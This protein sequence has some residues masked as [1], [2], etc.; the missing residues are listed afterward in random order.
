MTRIACIIPARLASTRFPRKMLSE[1]WGKP[2][3]L[4]VWEAAKAVPDF[5]TVAVATDSEEIARCI[6][7]EGG[8]ALL[9]DPSCSSGTARLVE[10]MRKGTIHAD[11]WVNWQGDE[12]LIHAGMIKELLQSAN[13]LKSDIWTLRREIVNPL[14]LTNPHIT[15]VVCDAA[16]FALYFS[17]SPIPHSRHDPP[18]TSYKHVGLYAFTNRALE[19]IVDLPPCALEKVEQLEQLRWLFHGLKIKVHRTEHEVFGIDLPEHLAKANAM[20]QN[21][22]RP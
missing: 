11:I 2:L 12:P 4:R 14:D 7:Q 5:H 15:K 1:L 6:E 10:I 3:I 18:S 20:Y 13:A 16:E 8:V 19:R 21:S 9:T 22:V 17:R